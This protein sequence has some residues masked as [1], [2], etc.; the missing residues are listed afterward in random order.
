MPLSAA[1]QQSRKTEARS[2][3]SIAAASAQVYRQ[4]KAKA[5]GGACGQPLVIGGIG[6]QCAQRRAAQGDAKQRQVHE[7]QQQ[8]SREKQHPVPERALSI[9]LQQRAEKPG[10]GTS[11]AHRSKAWRQMLQGGEGLGDVNALHSQSQASGGQD[12]RLGTSQKGA[13]PEGGGGR[14]N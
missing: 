13:A 3:K 1:C 6:Q 12:L 7:G 2:K 4:P 11:Q 14:E 5:Y 9:R 8:R 10:R